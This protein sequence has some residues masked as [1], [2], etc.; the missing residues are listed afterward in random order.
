MEVK[1]YIGIRMAMVGSTAAIFRQLALI[2]DTDKATVLPSNRQRYT[3]LAFEV[4]FC[5]VLPALAMAAHYIVQP[6]RYFLLAVVGCVPSFSASWA[7]YILIA[8]WPAIICLISVGYCLVAI[9]RLIRYRRSVSSILSNSSTI[10]KARYIRLF[11]IA[12]GLLFLYFPLAIYTLAS[13]AN[14]ALTPFSWSEVHGSGWSRQFQRLD[15]ATEKDISY[16]PFDRW[17]YVGT[18]Y[19]LFLLFGLGHEAKVMY[20]SWH[21]K[22]S[23]AKMRSGICARQQ[24]VS[25]LANQMSRPAELATGHSS[26]API[27]DAVDMELARIDN[28]FEPT[29][30]EL[31]GSQVGWIQELSCESKSPIVPIKRQI[32]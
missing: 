9:Y 10:S 30:S 18:G 15:E 8:V 32:P 26:R 22:L 20:M 24:S 28:D 6:N 14:Y 12:I 5:L 27:R 29:M 7:S 4:G 23:L 11:G 16:K 1:L 17:C 31:E 21:T 13:S 3:S 19:L 2:L 25:L